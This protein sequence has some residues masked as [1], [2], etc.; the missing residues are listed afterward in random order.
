[1]PEMGK[2][3]NEK[4]WMA[5]CVP[6]KMDE[7]ME[8]DQ[9]VA[10]C[11]SQWREKKSLGDMQ[12]EGTHDEGNSADGQDILVN[13]GSEIK[14]L[15]GKDGKDFA[16]VYG[17]EDLVSDYFDA[18]TEYGFAGAK[19]KRVPIL[20]HHALPLEFETKSG[21]R[22]AYHETS[23]IGEAELEQTDEGVIIREAILYN[24]KKYEEH[25]ESLGWSSGA[26]SHAVVRKPVKG[27]KNYVKQW[28]ISELSM[29][30]MSAEPRLK[31]VVSVKALAQGAGARDEAE[32]VEQVQ[33]NK[34]VIKMELTKEELAELVASASA[35]AAEKAVKKLAD[36]LPEV[37]TGFATETKVEVV[38]DE[39]DQP[40]ESLAQQLEAVKTF[41]SSYGQQYDPRLKSLAIKAP[42]GLNEGIPSQGGFLLSPTISAEFLKPIHEEGVFSRLVRRLPVGGNS[43]SGWI[44]GIDETS[45][46]NG[47]R[48]G[49]VQAY[50]RAEAGTVTATKP[51]FR[52]VNWEL[53]ALEALMYITDE[54]L[55]DAAMTAAIARESAAEELMF[56]VNDAIL[57]G[58]GVGKPLGVLNSGA[59]ISA[60]RTN[61]NDILFADILGMWQRLHPAH[62][63][64]SYWFVNSE[65]EP[66][67]DQLYLTTSLE[68]RYVT[69]GTDGVMRIK[70]RPV[71]V[72]EFNP[73]LGAVG[74]I[75]L[76]D[77]TD[78]LMWEKGGVQSSIN[79]WIQWLTSEQAFKFTLRVDGK[80]ATY[81][82]LTPYKGTNTQSPYVALAATT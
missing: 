28:F 60:T 73:G 64:N 58:D 81:S 24:R 3:D 77:M 80:P 11:L 22:N 68:S 27:G 39:A 1:M 52:R 20:F 26:P 78:Y 70:G 65:A 44:N 41:A 12:T 74:D 46:V 21:K 66:K 51:K 37:K 67:L 56:K 30:P 9:A 75:L 13:F 35:D 8:N 25:L 40:F 38:K 29:T 71:I 62:R 31:Q 43:N 36:E 32:T 47:S 34:G 14:S 59:L 4:D 72:T 82:A 69:Y 10:V 23:P 76:A 48:W 54:Q 45:R 2:Y 50:W 18:K 49:G 15:N 79:P 42:L 7:G 55:Q 33:N 16:V 53:N 5:A 63:A 57:S 61:A 6:M 19:T 17:G